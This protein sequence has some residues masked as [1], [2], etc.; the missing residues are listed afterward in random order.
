MIRMF[1]KYMKKVR[2]HII[3]LFP[4]V[5]CVQEMDVR[6]KPVSA[7][8]VSLC[9][10]CGVSVISPRWAAWRGSSSPWERHHRNSTHP[11]NTRPQTGSGF[12]FESH[13][14]FSLNPL[15]IVFTPYNEHVIMCNSLEKTGK[16]FP[17]IQDLKFNISI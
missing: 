17:L 10:I 13:G 3:V 16:H 11:Q 12:P 9:L 8:Y 6:L 5:G 4:P 7:L 1:V 2:R 14:L 15:D